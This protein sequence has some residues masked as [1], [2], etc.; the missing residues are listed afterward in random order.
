[1]ISTR[2]SSKGQITLPKKICQALQVKPGDRV[3][4]EI[5]DKA[6]LVR[7]IGSRARALAGGLRRYGGAK[8]SV[9]AV[10]ETVKKEV[11]RGTAQEG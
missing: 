1:M 8:A 7:P 3:C 2:V 4:F 10:R 5:G 9:G 6:V 11:A